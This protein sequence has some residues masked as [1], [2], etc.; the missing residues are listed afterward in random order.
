MIV[1]GKRHS[2]DFALDS[3]SLGVVAASFGFVLSCF[4]LVFWFVD[5][6]FLC[7]SFHN[8]FLCSSFRIRP[9]PAF[10]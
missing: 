7:S 6:V 4:V 10:F 3:G 9:H 1:L 5:E 2:Q 8:F